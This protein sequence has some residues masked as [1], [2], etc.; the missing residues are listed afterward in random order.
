[1]ERVGCKLSLVLEVVLATALAGCVQSGDPSDLGEPATPADADAAQAMLTID[2][3]V[4]DVRS[5]PS[6]TIGTYTLA[7]VRVARVVQGHYRGEFVI[8]QVRG[9]EYGGTITVVSEQAHIEVGERAR[10]FLDPLF[11]ADSDVLIEDKEAMA[12]TDRLD[13][14]NLRHGESGKIPLVAPDEPGVASTSAALTKGCGTT[15]GFCF[16]ADVS[17]DLSNRAYRYMVNPNTTDTQG[18]VPA[19]QMG[20]SAWEA[21]PDSRVDFAYMGTTPNTKVSDDGVNTV[22]WSST[23]LP[24]DT[25]AQTAVSLVG[26]SASGPFKVTGFDMVFN[27]QFKWGLFSDYLIEH[28]AMHEAGH[29]L[30]FGHVN[31]TADVMYPNYQPTV[32]LGAGDRAGAREWYRGAENALVGD[33]NGDGYD[34]IVTFQ[35]GSTAG[36]V[37]AALNTGTSFGNSSIWATG[38]AAAGAYPLLAR[39]DGDNKADIAIIIPNGATAAVA[40]CTSTGWSFSNCA[41]WNTSF[42]DSLTYKA[43]DVNGDGKAD[44]IGFGQGVSGQVTVALSTG[45]SFGAPQIWLGS[46]FGIGAEVVDVGDIDA[47]GDA[48]LIAFANGASGAGGEVKVAKSNR[49]FF[50]TA[51][52]WLQSFC[53][54]DQHPFTGDINGDGRTD[55]LCA[56]DGGNLSYGLAQSNGTFSFTNTSQVFAWRNKTLYIARTPSPGSIVLFDH[57]SSAD[58]FVYTKSAGLSYWNNGVKWHDYF[59]PG[60]CP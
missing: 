5:F 1:M 30:G 60:P 38:M 9:G 13:V 16:S 43:G 58:V 59:A 2:G 47:D 40:V 42:P 49:S 34:D 27:D 53:W 37:W 44:L 11:K 22:F 24:S 18:V 52:T 12:W 14:W 48:D 54:A 25:V 51:T 20:F 39:F 4:M 31:D 10:F 57:C 55:V 56:V 26:P 28:T 32:R 29:T 41:F 35:N 21:E 45:T 23:L 19:V 46:G 3:E 17:Y 36:D 50:D 7:R 15:A 8:V 33:I 6:D